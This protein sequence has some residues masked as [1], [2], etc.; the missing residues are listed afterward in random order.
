MIGTLLRPRAARKSGSFTTSDLGLASM[1]GSGPTRAGPVV[2]EEKSL[3]IPALFRA[4]DNL[5]SHTA[6]LPLPVIE[7]TGPKTKE[8]DP[9]HRVHKLLNRSANKEMTAYNFRRS[10]MLHTV[11]WGNGVAEIEQNSMGEALAMWL[12]LPNSFTI[13]RVSGELKYQITRIDGSTDLLDPS[14][15]IHTSQLGTDGIVGYGLISRLAREN[16]GQALALAQFVQNFFGNNMQLGLIISTDATLKKE[17]RE[18]YTKMLKREHGGPDKA[19]GAAFIDGGAKVHRMQSDNKNAQLIESWTLSIQ[20]AARWLNVPPPLLYDLSRSTFSNISEL[21]RTYERLSLG[22]WF[23]NFKQEFTRKLFVG[24]EADTHFV[25][26]VTD[27]L[28]RGDIVTRYGAYQTA[29]QNGFANIDEVRAKENLNPLPDGKGQEYRVAMNTEPVGMTKEQDDNEDPDDDIDS[30]DDDNGNKSSLRTRI[31]K[32][33]SVSFDDAM[34]R[35]DAIEEK[36]RARAMKAGKLDEEWERKFRSEHGIRLR[37][38]LMPCV[39]AL[40]GA[41]RATLG[42]VDDGKWDKFVGAFTKSLVKV[43]N[44]HSFVRPLSS[45]ASVFLYEMQDKF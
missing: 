11:L 2:D 19:F 7:Q 41:I 3:T 9:L 12:L 16:T 29:L 33:H 27:A 20:D 24:S 26:F 1:F 25:E 15:V 45:T 14:E 23:E 32:A 22:P 18:E 4:V 28:I 6:M 43:V 44:V 39:D 8:R 38:A 17:D 36:A 31:A 35:M 5:C 10:H 40:A 37:S 21:I 42:E 13:R 34:K 30:D